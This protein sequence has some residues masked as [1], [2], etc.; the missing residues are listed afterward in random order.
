MQLTL[1][2]SSWNWHDFSLNT[3]DIAI[4]MKLIWLSLCKLYA[5][6]FYANKVSI[7]RYSSWLLCTCSGHGDRELVSPHPQSG[8]PPRSSTRWTPPG[9]S[10][11]A[12]SPVKVKR[13][14]TGSSSQ[15]SYITYPP[16]FFLSIQIRQ[17]SCLELQYPLNSL[18]R[19]YSFKTLTLYIWKN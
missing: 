7:Y 2:L 3:A 6:C 10:A 8:S 18:F 12:P 14:N 13:S 11:T 16:Q 4:S 19:C 15:T 1:Q 5:Y 17:I 9:P